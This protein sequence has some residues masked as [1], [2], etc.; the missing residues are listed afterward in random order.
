M[1]SDPLLKTEKKMESALLEGRAQQLLVHPMEGNCL[2]GQM[3]PYPH[4]I[5]QTTHHFTPFPPKMVSFLET[6]FV[7]LCF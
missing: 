1:M 5:C 7:E 2:K 4:I 6:L 3:S